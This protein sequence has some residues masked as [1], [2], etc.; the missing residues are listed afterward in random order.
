MTI[1]KVKAFVPQ[2]ILVAMDADAMTSV[3]DRITAHQLLTKDTNKVVETTTKNN[4]V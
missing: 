3:D 4:P 1:Q 2:G